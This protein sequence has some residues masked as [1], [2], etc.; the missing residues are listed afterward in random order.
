MALVEN[1]TTISAPIDL[2]YRA[3]QDYSVR[4]DWDP[5]PE[6]IAV[7]AGEQ[8]G[9]SVGTQVHIKSKLGMS[10]L[11]EFVQVLPPSR[12]AVKMI[13][14]PWFLA[15]FVGSWIFQEASSN[16]TTARFRYT[17]VAKPTLLRFLVEPLASWYFSRVVN[18]RL[19]GLKAYCERQA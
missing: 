13:Q 10:M 17:I 14:G 18:K 7:V 5:F 8:N 19:A 3:S 2:V 12:A 11:V 4:Y 15:K 1:H 6:N 9:P 16:A